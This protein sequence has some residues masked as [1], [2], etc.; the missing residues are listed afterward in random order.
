MGFYTD[1]GSG[2]RTNGTISDFRAGGNVVGARFSVRPKSAFTLF[3]QIFF[4]YRRQTG[5]V[6]V[7][8]VAKPAKM[9]RKRENRPRKCPNWNQILP[10]PA[11]KNDAMS[12]LYPANNAEFGGADLSGF[13]SPWFELAMAFEVAEDGEKTWSE[14]LRE[15]VI[16]VGGELLFCLPTAGSANND[17]ERA[18]V[19]LSEDKLIFITRAGVD[20]IFEAEDETDDALAAFARASLEVMAR[21][22]DD[23]SVLAPLC[24]QAH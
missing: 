10:I 17:G 2:N 13:V 5:W 4:R 16:A 12:S 22:R 19:R 3:V 18:V 11:R 20:T 6:Y 8:N 14:C 21:L 15:S 24:E 7:N 23:E 9:R 1:S